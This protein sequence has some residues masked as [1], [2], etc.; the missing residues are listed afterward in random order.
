MDMGEPTDSATTVAAESTVTIQ[1]IN[2]YFVP[3]NITI[4]AGKMVELKLEN[5]DGQEHDLQV[6]GLEVE[7]MSGGAMDATHESGGPGM[8]AVHTL[9]NETSSVVFMATKPGTYDFYC[10]LPGHKDAGMVGKLTVE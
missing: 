4:P 5:M 1:A 10:T 9:A 7:M 2:A 8:L 3:D 6:D